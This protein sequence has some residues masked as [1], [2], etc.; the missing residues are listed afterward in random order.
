MDGALRYANG[1]V[2]NPCVKHLPMN[3]MRIIT[4]AALSLFFCGCGP[5]GISLAG[6]PWKY[7]EVKR[8]KSPDPA[9]EAVLITGDAGATTSTEYYLY[10]VPTGQRINPEKAGEN[11][12]CFQAYHVKDLNPV[13]KNAKLLEIQYGEAVIDQFH[14][15]WQH[16]E[17]QDFRYVVEVR[18]APTS[19]EF[20]I[21]AQ[22]RHW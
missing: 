17:V 21:P 4:T 7:S 3:A 8:I 2:Y 22:D 16:R 19:P 13:W 14:N 5:A 9:V 1:S 12:P 15:L 18:L 20:S 11:R 10:L 6:G